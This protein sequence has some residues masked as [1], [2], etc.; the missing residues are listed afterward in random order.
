MMTRPP[1]DSDRQYLRLLKRRQRTS[2]WH[3]RLASVAVLLAL[4]CFIVA[5]EARSF[6]PLVWWLGIGCLFLAL[7]LLTIE[8]LDAAQERSYRQKRRL[9]TKRGPS[10][11]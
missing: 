4:V 2:L 9:L 11:T 10:A 7:L 8:A 1:D 6:L 3:E 5:Q